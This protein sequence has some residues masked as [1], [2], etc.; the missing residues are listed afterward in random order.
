MP[1]AAQVA[2]PPVPAGVAAA[3]GSAD[4]PICFSERYG[5]PGR[6]RTSPPSWSVISSSG[7]RT[8][9]SGLASAASS[10]LITAVI[11][12]RLEMLPPKKITPAASPCR[13]SVSS[14]PAG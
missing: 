1:D 4:S 12:A 7:A 10:A 5:G 6:R 3:A 8:G 11:C 9:F 2:P 13:I 14:S